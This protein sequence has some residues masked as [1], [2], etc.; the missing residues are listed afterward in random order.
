MVLDT[1]NYKLILKLCCNSFEKKF[2]TRSI[3]F[4]RIDSHSETYRAKAKASSIK[5]ARSA[6]EKSW[7]EKEKKAGNMNLKAKYTEKLISLRCYSQNKS[8]TIHN[9]FYSYRVV[10]GKIG[11]YPFPSW[12]FIIY[13]I[14]PNM[15]RVYFEKSIST[16][17]R[18][19][20][21]S[22]GSK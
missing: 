10:E 9:H 6:E 22:C 8:K 15:I 2:M 12:Y 5:L 14:K 17:S 1:L 19:Q 21:D 7:E 18:F 16:M 11:S 20:S 4:Y 13:T 3:V